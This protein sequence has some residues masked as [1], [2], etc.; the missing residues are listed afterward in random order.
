V[1]QMARVGVDSLLAM[2]KS[3][4]KTR[5]TSPHAAPPCRTPHTLQCTSLTRAGVPALSYSFLPEVSGP[6]R[7]VKAEPR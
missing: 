2:L 1:I 3:D 5:M 7:L 6:V 4:D